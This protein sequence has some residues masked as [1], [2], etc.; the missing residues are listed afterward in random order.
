MWKV[1][2]WMKVGETAAQSG[3]GVRLPVF[4]VEAD[5]APV[6]QEKAFL[7][8]TGFGPIGGPIDFDVSCGDERHAGQILIRNVHPQVTQFQGGVWKVTGDRS[9]NTPG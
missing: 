8:L 1:S 6:A 5:L 2:G 9:M 7:V 3:S 4:Y